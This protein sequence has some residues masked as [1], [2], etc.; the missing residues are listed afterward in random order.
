MR[1]FRHAPIKLKLTL[2][3]MLTSM[4]TLLVA[5]VVFFT[6]DLLKFR[7]LMVQDLAT[8]AEI[9]GS[10]ARGALI[11]RDT[12]MA[13]RLLAGMDASRAIMEV[14][15]LLPDGTVLGRY[16]RAQLPPDSMIT[17]A[18]IPAGHHRFTSRHLT[19][20]RD[21]IYEDE[22]LGAVYLRSDLRDLY[23]HLRTYAGILVL[24]FVA[25]SLV[26][27]FLSR[28]LQRVIS[29]P[30]LH[31]AAVEREVARRKDF[32]MRAVKESE[33]E[34]GELIDGFN[35]M[36]EEIQK[37]DAEVRIAKERAEDAS[38]TKS[39]FLANMS[40]EL[41]TPLNAIIGYSE[42]LMEEVE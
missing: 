3:T 14:A 26:A 32:S 25:S 9:M 11:F 39:A 6:Y 33:D 12:E 15:V 40:H 37:R 29:G 1:D 20:A 35:E 38:R 19:L 30:I 28:R 22:K 24:I 34:L 23:E 8:L 42:M 5:C 36:L 31:L 27:L 18:S 2:I 16:R 4:V 41:R 13:G 17:A 10:T 21:V 7:R